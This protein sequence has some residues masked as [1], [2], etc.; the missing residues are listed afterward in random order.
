MAKRRRVKDTV[1]VYPELDE[2]R[3][4]TG[5][6]VLDVRSGSNAQHSAYKAI[7]SGS[8]GNRVVERIRDA[9]KNSGMR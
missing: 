4:P 2:D 9:Q 8:D 1:F 7:I 3:T 5:D 6:L